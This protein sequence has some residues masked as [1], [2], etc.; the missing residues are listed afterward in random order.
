[1]YIMRFI[2]KLILLNTFFALFTLNAQMVSEL[3]TR[4]I[5]RDGIVYFRNDFSGARLN[6]LRIIG[7]RKYMA[8][9]CP[10]YTPINPSLSM[11][12]M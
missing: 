4:K 5:W 1:M 3:Q 10:E 11:L 12:L 7:D 9:I 6:D 8:I 2:G